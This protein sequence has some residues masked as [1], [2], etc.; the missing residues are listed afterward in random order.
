MS[1]MGPPP[2]PPKQQNAKQGAAPSDSLK[3]RNLK[4]A[5]DQ[6]GVDTSEQRRLSRENYDE[7]QKFINDKQQSKRKESYEELKNFQKELD[8]KKKPLSPH[9][10]KVKY[11]HQQ[12][13]SSPTLSKLHEKR[14]KSQNR[15]VHHQERVPGL[16]ADPS[17]KIRHLLV[18][19]FFYRRQEEKKKAMFEPPPPPPPFIEKNALPPRQVQHYPMV[20]HQAPTQGIPPLQSQG[21]ANSAHVVPQAPPPGFNDFAPPQTYNQQ[22]TFIAPKVQ[23]PFPS[24]S[25]VKLSSTA[26]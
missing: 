4:S 24:G 5:M 25:G 7:Y 16:R 2:L 14:Y 23:F 26:Q 17:V 13:Q 22:Q 10:D 19:R 6:L 20:P 1:A 11:D 8:S 12:Q 3:K 21:L 15:G 18:E 9:I